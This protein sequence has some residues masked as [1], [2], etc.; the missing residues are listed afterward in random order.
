MQSSSHSLE[1]SLNIDK[2]RKGTY[3]GKY[4]IVYKN[5]LWKSRTFSTEA[6]CVQGRCWPEGAHAMLQD[7]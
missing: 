5:Y 4:N 1:F 7:K 6:K 2:L 3:K